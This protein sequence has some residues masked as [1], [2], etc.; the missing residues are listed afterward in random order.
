[1][2]TL[3][4]I[5]II[6]LLPVSFF[7][8]A[9]NNVG[10][11]AYKS[12]TE[13]YFTGLSVSEYGI[14]ATNNYASSLYLVHDGIMEILFSSA[15]CGRYYTLSPDRKKIGFKIIDVQHKN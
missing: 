3:K 6:L 14:V 9:G 12:E 4:F 15:G 8:N 5:I 13:G 7:L 11:D 1:M 2:N 10:I